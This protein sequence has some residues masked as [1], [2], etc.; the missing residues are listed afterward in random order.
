MYVDG[1]LVD[2]GWDENVKALSSKFTLNTLWVWRQVAAIVTVEKIPSLAARGP[3]KCARLKYL[4]DD[5]FQINWDVFDFMIKMHISN[6]NKSQ[7]IFVIHCNRWFRQLSRWCRWIWLD[8]FHY[9]LSDSGGLHGAGLVS[10]MS[11]ALLFWIIQHF[12]IT[13]TPDGFVYCDADAC[14]WQI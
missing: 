8:I 11:S 3:R 1:C 12:W 13:W 9:G 7:F 6:S 14:V 4:N 10:G 5:R 2:G